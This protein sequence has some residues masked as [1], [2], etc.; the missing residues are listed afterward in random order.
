MP[1][2][3][4]L[5]KR[6]KM[7]GNSFFRNG[8]ILVFA[9]LCLGSC[10]QK[11]SEQEVQAYLKA[12]AEW[13]QNRI[14]G[15]KAPEGYLNLAGLYWLEKGVNTFGSDSSNRLI[16]P[17]KAPAHLGLLRVTN[18]ASVLYEPQPGMAAALSSNDSSWTASEMQVV[19]DDSL[20][21]ATKMAL[22]SLSWH[23]IKRG[24]RL[25][26][27][28]RDLEHPALDSLRSIDYYP[29][30]ISW[31][32]EATFEPYDPPKILQIQNVIGI[33]YDQPSPGKLVFERDGSFFSLDVTEEG[34]R[35]FVT[36]AD[37][38]SGEDTYGGGRYLYTSRPGPDGKVVLD[39][40]KAYNPPCVYTAFATCP[41]PPP[42]NRLKL[43]VL[44]GE[45]LSKK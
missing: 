20:K 30:D 8:T 4:N 28:L 34:D 45:K 29:V 24:D 39:F 40:N 11:M 26:L 13:Q 37:E 18:T 16:F 14:S 12:Y 31:R 21:I 10:E 33:T 22:G 42:Q 2:L 27:R 15:L 1:F 19:Y 36:F 17:A 3:F 44:A 25:G 6:T 32:L 9:A 38:T 23:V 41:L 7:A 43:A 35:F 5:A